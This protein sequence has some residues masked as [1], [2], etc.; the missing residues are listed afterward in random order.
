MSKPISNA[1][2]EWS[3]RDLLIS[4]LVVYMAMAVLALAAVTQARST[5]AVSPGNLMVQ[6]WWAPD[7]DADVDLW[8]E[9][10]GDTPIGYSNRS[11]RT[12]NLLRDDLG[13]GA[14]IMSQNYEIAIGRGT[15]EGE[16]TV[17]AHLYRSRAGQAPLD[18]RIT[19]TVQN[20]SAPREILNERFTLNHEGQEKTVVRFSLSDQG[21]LKPGSIL[22]LFKPIRAEKAG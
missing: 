12:F 5:A 19:V 18:G 4:L 9:A 21:E 15:P 3:Y 14:D 7:A 10:P 11:G 22:H 8:V 2:F 13:R 1:G 20:G 6:L 17:N 16:Y